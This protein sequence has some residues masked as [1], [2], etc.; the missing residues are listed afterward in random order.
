QDAF[1]DES[2][3]PISSARFGDEHRSV[4]QLL[5]ELKASFQASP[6]SVLPT[7]RLSSRLAMVTICDYEADSALPRLAAFAHGLYAQAHGYG[8]VHHRT[9]ELADGRAPAWGKVRA[10][11]AALQDGRWDWVAWVDCDLYFMDLNKTLDSLLLTYAPSPESESESD[12]TDPEV[13]LLISEDSQTLNTA[14]FFL[15]RGAWS[16]QLLKRVWQDPDGQPSAFVDHTWW[17]QQA[18]AQELLGDNLRRFGRLRYA[19]AAV[20]AAAGF[21]LPGV[22]KA[23]PPQVRIIPQLEMNSYHPISSRL[24]DET[25]SPG[26]FVLSFNGEFRLPLEGSRSSPCLARQSPRCSM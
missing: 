9:S 5:R 2:P 10:M 24:V 7:A 20:H 11:L 12:E 17:E 6:R 3:W 25:W 8:Y 15:R 14:I 18:F 22:L 16:E 26:K 1:I 19:R 21:P 23:Y 4:A 13:N